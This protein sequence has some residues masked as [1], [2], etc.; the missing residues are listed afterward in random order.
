MLKLLSK[1]ER[2]RS[3]II[4]GFA[5]LL[6]LSLVVFYAP[7]RSNTSISSTNTE[8]LASVNGEEI[9]VGDVASTLSA[10]GAD[11]SMLNRQIGELL[12]KQLISDRVKVQ[13]A[14]RLGLTVSDAELA[15]RIRENN[16]DSSGKVDMKRY[17]E[18][19][20]DVARFEE[21]VRDSI[22]IEKLRAFITASVTVSEEELQTEFRRRNTEFDLVY[23]P[24]VADKLAAKISASDQELR[25]YYE[26]H[27]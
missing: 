27:K 14:E 21:Q 12:L 24:I 20:G 25:A 16:K 11:A 17:R 13:E 22:A 9:T 26:Q 23:V 10:R 2:T 18:S 6:A 15:E 5:V 19:V 8:V 1:M 4:V 7:S 3:L